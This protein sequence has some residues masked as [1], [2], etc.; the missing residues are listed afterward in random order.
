M[1][2]S[3]NMNIKKKKKSKNN[4][5]LP[6]LLLICTILLYAIYISLST[7]V[8][9][10][11][12]DSVLGTVDSYQSRLDST[13]ADVNRSRTISKGYYFFYAGKEYSGYVIY[14]S[15][16]AWP[17]L[18]EGETRSER[19]TFLSFFPYINK[20]S[21]LTEFDEMGEVAIIYHMLAPIGCFLL[22]LLVT[23][24]ALRTSRKKNKKSAASNVPTQTQRAAVN[25]PPAPQINA[26]NTFHNNAV[27]NG[28]SQTYTRSVN[29]MFCF[30]CGAS[31]P[32]DTEFCINCGTALKA[33]E[34]PPNT[35][36]AA[37]VSPPQDAYSAPQQE[38]YQGYAAP[39]QQNAHSGY[40][41]PPQQGG[42]APQYDPYA[43]KPGLIGFSDRLHSPEILTAAAKNKKSAMGCMWVMVLLPLV[44]FPIAGLLIDEYPF[45]ESVVIGIVVALIMLVI[46]LSMRHSQNKP[47]WE[48]TV[49]NKYSKERS[50]HRGGEDDNRRTY[51]E[52]T[53]VITTDAGKTK[54]IVEKDSSNNMYTYL[55]VG[56]RVRYHP[57]FV[58][59]EKY[60]KSRDR[61]IYCMIC[62]TMN[63][64]KNDRCERCDNLLFK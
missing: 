57:M 8:L 36:Q 37:P 44:G 35:E 43:P 22:L 46:N 58:A 56:D 23:R 39:P 40:A 49:V 31:L 60:D 1:S 7:L 20:P 19:I 53:T 13:D 25:Q 47:I 5:P 64:I 45:G 9:A 18:D 50:E 32:D 14:S 33:A 27:Q 11:W 6:I 59:Y 28:S 38:P 34:P 24:T 2:M 15:D 51:T 61:I 30:N 54:K 52:F 63:P 48:G 10:I 29:D 17:D 16:E 26:H 41:A 21:S 42:Y 3:E 62:N 55:N 12:G 4:I